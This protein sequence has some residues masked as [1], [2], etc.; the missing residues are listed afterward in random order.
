MADETD[1]LYQIRDR[2]RKANEALESGL[3]ETQMPTLESNLDGM[4]YSVG[5]LARDPIGLSRES[6]MDLKADAEMLEKSLVDWAAT[7]SGA[8]IDF[9]YALA[10]RLNS[11]V[12]LL[13]YYGAQESDAGVDA[14]PK[15]GNL[16]DP[17]SKP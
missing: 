7:K 13:G 5:S 11:A 8:Q 9:T 15:L 1:Y 16:F 2:L 12:S 4:I 6:V 10:A 3:A 17:S 14:D